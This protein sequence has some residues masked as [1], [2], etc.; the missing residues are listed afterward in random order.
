MNIPEHK[1]VKFFHSNGGSRILPNATFVYDDDFALN[2]TSKY[3]ELVN[4][5]PS[6]LLSI[7]SGSSL[8]GGQIPSGQ[9]ALQGMQ[10]WQG[11]EPI[12]FN[13]GLHLYMQYDATQDVYIPSIEISKLAVPTRTDS[14]GHEGWGLIPPGPNLSDILTLAGVP[15]DAQDDTKYI[16]LKLAEGNGLFDVEVGGFFYFQNC[17]ITKAVPNYSEARDENLAPISCEISLDFRTS[18]IATKQL[19]DTIQVSARTSSL[20]SASKPQPKNKGILNFNG[21][22]K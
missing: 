9:F 3:G 5:K 11:S 4:V 20:S 8:L 6:N 10:I 12:E 18:E 21:R 17:I 16:G 14:N 2:I 15:K 1:Q 22:N 19:L 7:L 13:L